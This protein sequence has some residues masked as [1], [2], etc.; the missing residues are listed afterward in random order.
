MRE[1]HSNTGPADFSA[2][3]QRLEI[4]KLLK[5]SELSCFGEGVG[6]GGRGAGQW[7]QFS[8]QAKRGRWPGTSE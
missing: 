1:S 2:M 8:K 5:L 6:A 4:S 3:T 7:I